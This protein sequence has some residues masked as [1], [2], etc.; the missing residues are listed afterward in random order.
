M[1]TSDYCR[2]GVCFDPFHPGVPQEPDATPTRKGGGGGGATTSGNV[3]VV[4]QTDV[5][6][7]TTVVMVTVTE[8]GMGGQVTGEP[9]SE[10]G[11]SG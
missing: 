10:D 4:T 1:G 7:A 6:F 2:L 8:D 11:R 5:T 3:V 9:E